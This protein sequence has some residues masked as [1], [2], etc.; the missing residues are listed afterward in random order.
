M[1][2]IY[3]ISSIALAGF[4]TSCYDL[5]TEPMSSVI[6]EAQRE[7]IVSKDPAAIDAIS[8]G[9]YA[10][11]NGFEMCYGDLLDFGYPAVMLQLDSRT[12]NFLS[13]NADLYGWFA[14]CAE[15]LDNTAT[16]VYT[17]IRWRLPYNIIFTANQVLSTIDENTEDGLMKYYRGQ[18]YGN[19]AFAYWFLAQIY[20]FNYANHQ[21]SPCVPII[22]EENADEVAVDGAPRA[23]VKDVYAQ[24]LSDLNKGIE[25]MTD[26]SQATRADKRYIDLNVL[27]GLRARTYLCMEDYT[28]AAAD[29]QTVINSGAFTPLS[30]SAAIGPGFIDLDSANWIWGIYMASE[31]VNGL[32]T[33][34]GMMGSYTYGYAYAGMWKCITN[35]LYGQISESDPRKLWWIGPSGNSNAQYYTNADGNAAAYLEESGFPPYAVTKFAPYGNVLGQSQNQAEYPL[36]RIEEMYYILAEA[37]GMGGNLAQG[38]QTLENFVNSYRWLDRNNPY[39]CTAANTEDFISE[40]FFQR[41]VELWGEGMTYFDVMRLNLDIDRRGTNWSDPVYGMTNYAYYIPAGSDVLLSQ[42]PRSEIDNNKQITDAD[43]NTPGV[44]SL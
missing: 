32:Y 30:P 10:N 43:N 22:T 4:M 24:I 38:I 17:L 6:T 29:A 5:N 41:Q 11:Y 9:V 1:K 18:A 12:S 21:D 20:Q 13:A 26:N 28:N 7:E 37:Q 23:S 27:Y 34:S 31:D 44:A 8:S 2:K 15:Y 35:T 3:I 33:L 39:K 40:I 25:L 36:M 19:R 14:E 42:I 16:S